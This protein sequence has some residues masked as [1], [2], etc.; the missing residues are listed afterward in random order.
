MVTTTKDQRYLVKFNSI[1]EAIT[2]I[3]KHEPEDELREI[4]IKALIDGLID[5][6]WSKKRGEL[7]YWLT[8]D[9]I[10]YGEEI[11]EKVEKNFQYN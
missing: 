11:E 3:E 5:L 7:I 6:A 8:E 1:D 10:K 2:A 4:L 9:G